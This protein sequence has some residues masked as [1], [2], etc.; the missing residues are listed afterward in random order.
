MF[1]LSVFLIFA[2]CKNDEAVKNQVKSPV[3]TKEEKKAKI[4]GKKDTKDAKDIK[5]TK[6]NNSK[7]VSP[8]LLIGN[9]DLADILGLDAKDISISGGRGSGPSSKSCS[10]SWGKPGE[11]RNIIHLS[12]Q[13]N[14]LPGEFENFGEAFINSKIKNGDMGYPNEGKPY[15]Y[16][17]LDGY[18]SLAAY[19]DDL[20]RLYWNHGEEYVF[21]IYYNAG[22]DS[23]TRKKHGLKIAKILDSNFDKK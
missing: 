9:K 15:K 11:V 22:L 4:T 8:C 12:I 6:D 7:L 21:S 5:N 13:M 2:S 20:R 17:K 16:Q 1:I 18:N 14:P 19:N 3:T 10:V 23:K